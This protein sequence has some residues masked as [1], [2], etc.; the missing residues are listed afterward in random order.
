M[1]WHCNSCKMI[2][3]DHSRKIC[4]SGLFQPPPS[5]TSTK[6]QIPS[7]IFLLQKFVRLHLLTIP[8]FFATAI[9]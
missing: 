6:S 1:A 7:E 9:D 3:I 2:L 5:A 8:I 4:L